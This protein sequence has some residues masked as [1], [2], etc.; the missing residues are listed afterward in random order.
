MVNNKGNK[1]MSNKHALQTYLEQV[2]DDGYEFKIRSYS[3]RGM[4]G[5]TCV[6]VTLD[7][8][9]ISQ[10]ELIARVVAAAAYDGAEKAEEE[11]DFAAEGVSSNTMDIVEA[12]SN[13]NTDSMGLGTV[14]YWPNVPYV[15]GDEATEDTE[16]EEDDS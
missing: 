12:M 15:A 5:A 16:E 4:F 14:V 1:A 6:A 2:R 13:T 9:S 7:R 11:G 10:C 8:Y 3:G